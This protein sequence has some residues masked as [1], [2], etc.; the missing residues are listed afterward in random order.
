MSCWLHPWFQLVRGG[1]L[2]SP[3]GP[4]EVRLLTGVLDGLAALASGKRARVEGVR[5]HAVR[6]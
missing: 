3:L 4:A 5:L 6:R 1:E 2:F